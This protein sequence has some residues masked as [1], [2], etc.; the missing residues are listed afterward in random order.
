METLQPYAEGKWLILESKPDEPS[1]SE[2]QNEGDEIEESLEK[3]LI[4]RGP[5]WNY[6]KKKDNDEILFHII[7]KT[8]YSQEELVLKGAQWIPSKPIIHSFVEYLFINMKRKKNIN[9]TALVE[10]ETG[11]TMTYGELIHNA[12]S[13]ACGLRWIG[14]VPGQVVALFSYNSLEA[15][16]MILASLLVGSLTA[17]LESSYNSVELAVQLREVN[18]RL[19]FTETGKTLL[20]VE[21]ALT[22]MTTAR[23]PRVVVN[24]LHPQPRNYLTIN[25]LMRE[26]EPDFKA[27]FRLAN[28]LN[29]IFILFSCGTTASAKGTLISERY[30]T[31]SKMFSET[32]FGISEKRYTTLISSPIFWNSTITT[33]LLKLNYGHRIVFFRGPPCEAVLIKALHKFQVLLWVTSPAVLLQLLDWP[34][35][36]R[37]DFLKVIFTIGMSF[38]LQ[39]ITRVR[40]ELFS[41]KVHICQVYGMTETG[42]LTS[43]TPSMNKLGSVGRLSHNTELKVMEE[44]TGLTLGAYQEGELCFK[45]QSL[46]LGYYKNPEAT[47]LMFDSEG[48][49]HTGDLGYYD[50]QGFLF[51]TGRKKEVIKWK[52]YQIAPMDIEIQ[53]LTLPEVKEAVVFGIPNDRDGEIVT[54]AVILHPEFQITA[55]AELIEAT[56]NLNLSNTKKIRGGV[57]I[58]QSFPYTATGKP[59]KNLIV[60]HVLNL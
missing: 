52:S 29:P 49:F 51:I 13:L 30:F 1:R 26:V 59:I 48:F 25:Q 54:A 45:S 56:A 50:S 32:D 35:R 47:Q 19:L 33:L 39:S 22:Q 20:K 43:N 6:G 12:Q 42:T 27:E 9:S 7:K 2:I 37:W 46:M 57:H 11:R 24:S 15:L 38:T 36:C 18:P 31:R 41:G 34:V 5:L 55:N 14:I 40:D 3:D 44:G 8:I 17:I 23:L 58:F 60:K 53:L 10:V 21:Y 4:L 16:I 28:S